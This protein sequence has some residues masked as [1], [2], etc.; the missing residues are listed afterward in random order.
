MLVDHRV[1]N[2]DERLVRV[3]YTMSPAQ[4]ISLKPAFNRVLDKDF[5]DTT[6]KREITAILIFLKVLAHPDLLASIVDRIELV[7]LCLV[8]AEDTECL[9]ILR[10]DVP[11]E[12][13]EQRH[14]ARLGSTGFCSVVSISAEIWH[15]KLVLQ[16][17]TIGNWICAH[18]PLPLRRKVFQLRQD[19]PILEQFLRLVA[20]HPLL[21]Y[22]EVLRILQHIR[23]RDLM[24]P[25]EALKVVVIKLAWSS[26]ALW[27]AEDNHRPSWSERLSRIS[28]LLLVVA[29]LCHACFECASH[30]LVHRFEV[31]ALHEE[32]LPAVA[33][34]QAVQLVVGDT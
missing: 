23:D 7:R 30:S 19:L 25:P 12:L 34:E 24:R 22:L 28:R 32:W 18:S 9:L 21:Q 17:P 20:A 6:C 4:N 13:A 14:A 5:H 29:D 31:I 8:G 11:Q 3:E 10:Y 26:P 1:D 15:A 2:V 33:L 27:R 16:R